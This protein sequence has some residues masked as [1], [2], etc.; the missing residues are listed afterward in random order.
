MSLHTL[1]LSVYDIIHS[2]RNSH[3]LVAVG[4]SSKTVSNVWRVQRFAM[5]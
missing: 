5:G 1:L 3:L 2:T 4:T